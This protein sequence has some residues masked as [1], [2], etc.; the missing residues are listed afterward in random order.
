M[1]RQI[2][3]LTGL[4]LCLSVTQQTFVNPSC[5]EQITDE[6][7]YDIN[8]T[9]YALTEDQE[10][11]LNSIAD[12]LVGDWQGEL[13]QIECNGSVKN[14]TKLIDSSAVK[15]AIRSHN[16]Q[17][18]LQMRTGLDFHQQNKKVIYARKIFE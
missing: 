17:R 15:L 3:S 2:R 11:Y 5:N 18:L 9:V 12:K 10:N 14:P 1:F 13:E 6:R 8:K 7:Y 16:Q 4:I